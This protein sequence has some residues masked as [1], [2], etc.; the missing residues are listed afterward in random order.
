MLHTHAAHMWEFIVLFDTYLTWS[1]LIESEYGSV[2]SA[3]LVVAGFESTAAL[4][5]GV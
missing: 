5:T 1:N 4:V 2:Q 3:A